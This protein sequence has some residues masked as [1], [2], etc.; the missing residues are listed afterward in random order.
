MSG[1]PFVGGE[2]GWLVVVNAGRQYALWR[3]YL[4]VPKGRRAVRSCPDRDG[5]LDRVEQNSTAAVE[6]PTT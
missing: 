1:N 6:T 3:P 2:A 4:D 5:A